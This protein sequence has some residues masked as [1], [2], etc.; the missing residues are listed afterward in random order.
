MRTFRCACGERV[1]FDNTQCLACGRELGFFS[2]A[3]TVV[4]LEPAV[5]GVHATPYGPCRK[6]ENYAARG[7]CN[8]LVP[9]DSDETLCR[10][11][12]LN[13]VVPD[14]SNSENLALWGE[15]E[16]AKRRLI[17]TLDQL[18]LPVVSQRDDPENGLAFDIAADTGARRV[19]T[20]HAD[21]LIT[22]NLG[23]ADALTRERV[24]IAFKERYRTLLG[25]FRHEIGHY[26]WERLVRDGDKLEL[27]RAHFG[28]ETRDYSAC[29]AAHHAKAPD[30]T[31]STDFITAYASSHP[32]EDWAETFAHYLLMLDTLDTSR[33]FGFA[34]AQAP[35]LGVPG[36]TDFDLMIDAWSEL[37]V[38]LNA[39]SRSMGLPDLYPFAISPV[40]RDKLEAVHRIVREARAAAVRGKSTPPPPLEEPL[41]EEPSRTRI[42][43]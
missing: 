21:G 8:W 39:V 1:F 17:Y 11:C 41:G 23:E 34:N 9:I 25:H 16:K 28:D 33:E 36:S 15:V 35:D 6:C 2:E 20:G 42:A 7:V 4:G 10:A 29:L 27:F 5:D 19:L 24:R 43:V 14:L 13:H 26:F 31:W 37:S 3:G 12:R 18:R 32:W 22:L 40:V 38:A 30:S